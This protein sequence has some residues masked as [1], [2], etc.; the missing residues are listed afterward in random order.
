MKTLNEKI[1]E[2]K[3]STIKVELKWSPRYV[4]HPELLFS[5]LIIECADVLN[6]D[7]N[8]F[9]LDKQDI[10]EYLEKS[11]KFLKETDKF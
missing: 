4:R 11:V 5:E 8:N 1:N 6:N 3:E 7:F 9:D 2:N 10:I